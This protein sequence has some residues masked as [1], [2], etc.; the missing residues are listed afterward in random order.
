MKDLTGLMKKA[1]EMQQRMS[2][3]QARLDDLEVVGESGAGMIKVT[4]TAKGE[5]RGLTIDP[6]VIDKDE[7][8]V[9]EDLIKAAFSDAKRKADEAQAQVMGE[10]TKG[11]GLPPGF[12]L[13]FGMKGPF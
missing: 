8:E 3:A 11:M 2:E 10:A 4:L 13:P 12:D 5:M 7:A 1:Q 9:L 6:S